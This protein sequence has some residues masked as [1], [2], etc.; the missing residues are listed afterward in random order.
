MR[1]FRSDVDEALGGADGEAGDGHAFDQAE[2]VPFHEHP[3]AEGAAVTLIRI[4]DDVLAVGL[5]MK[6]RV[7]LD[8]SRESG[9]AP[10]AQPRKLD[11]VHDGLR[12]QGQRASKAGIAA[13]SLVVPD[14]QRIDDAAPCEG[15]PLLPGEVGLVLQ[16]AEAQRV[17]PTRQEVGI[18]QAADVRGT[19]RPIGNASLGRLDLDQ[20][21]E[22]E[23]AA[24]P[25]RHD[26]QG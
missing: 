6:D 9:P 17:F 18:E 12:L 8:P 19:D 1:I 5:R 25:G 14:G 23:Q 16:V 26:L 3:V 4:A 2:G 21:F 13:M 10:S 20:G 7:P 24:R 15:Q 22:P 11:F